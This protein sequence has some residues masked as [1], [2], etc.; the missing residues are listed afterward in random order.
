MNIYLIWLFRILHIAAGVF[1]VGG[2]VDDD[3]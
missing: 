1:W 2:T 3:P